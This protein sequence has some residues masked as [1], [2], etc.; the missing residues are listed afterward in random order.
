MIEYSESVDDNSALW[1]VLAIV[2]I[3]LFIISLAVNIFL[4]IVRRRDIIKLQEELQQK[5]DAASSE[6]RTN[7]F[8]G[9]T[10][11]TFM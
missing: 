3:M 2:F 8:Y 6:S 4:W 9:G 1:L 10:K 11:S 5:F 7:V